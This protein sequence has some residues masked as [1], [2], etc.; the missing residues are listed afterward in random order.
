MLACMAGVCMA[1]AFSACTQ[2]PSSTSSWDTPW[3]WVV[4]VCWS[5][6]ELESPCPSTPGPALSSLPTLSFHWE[7]KRGSE[8]QYLPGSATR[9]GFPG[10]FYTVSPFKLRHLTLEEGDWVS[11]LLKLFL[12]L[13]HNRK[14]ER[15]EGKERTDAKQGKRQT[16]PLA[17]PNSPVSTTTLLSY[18]Y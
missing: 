10:F 18:L 11:A 1:G 16:I 7:W 3:G 14:V 4:F 17:P 6:L 9:N 5:N 13:G 15:N 8:G 2:G 12:G